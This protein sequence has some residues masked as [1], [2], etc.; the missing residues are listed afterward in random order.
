[1][2]VKRIV[3]ILMLLMFL[4]GLIL[5]L[6][7]YYNGLKLEEEMLG[8]AEAFLASVQAESPTADR[9]E[10]YEEDTQPVKVQKYPDLLRDMLAY[11]LKIYD[12]KQA[13]LNNKASYKTPSFRLADYGLDS[14]VFAVI[15]IPKLELQMPIYLG[16][17][18]SNTNRGAAHLSQT[19]LPIGGENTNCVLAGHRGW[20]GAD[21]FRYI[22]ELQIGDEITI[23]NLWET[24]TYTVTET[25]IIY[26]DEIEEILIQEGRDMLTLLTCHP[27]ASGGKQR[28]LVFCD[29]LENNEGGK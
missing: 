29:R 11:N 12:E 2:L 21:F 19:S 15:Q 23:T 27:Y 3:L 25:K 10:P 17:N 9:S 28:Y 18:A 7:P 13:S 16:A 14:E 5:I 26:P 22:T 4:A 1:M 8:E 20:N 6:Y 24:L